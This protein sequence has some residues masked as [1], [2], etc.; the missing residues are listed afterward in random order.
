MPLINKLIW[1]IETQLEDELT[2]EVLARRCA[3]NVHHMCRAFQL[4][5]GLSVMAYVR[6]RRLSRAA[7]VLAGGEADI[8]TTALEAGYGSHEA[9]TRAFRAY[10]GV[11]PR[12]VKGARDLS[13]L[14]LME[15][16]EMDKSMIVDVAAPEFR[17]H[18]AFRVVGMGAEVR[19]FDISAIPSLWQ[20]FAVQYQTLGASGET[21]GVSYDIGEAGDFRYIAGMEWPDVPEGMEAVEIPAARYAVF[22]HEGHIG[23]LPKTIYSVWNKALPDA[24]LEPALTPEFERYDERFDAIAGRGVVEFWVPLA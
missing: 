10:T 23:D 7:H 17:E 2:L 24:G 4:G 22:T 15:P 9:F 8:L 14:K 5:T 6:A 19:G 18:G 11:L 13:N 1:H 20:R 3:V 16:L 12:E 21:Y